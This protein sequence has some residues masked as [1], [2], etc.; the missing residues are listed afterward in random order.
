MIGFLEY[1]GTFRQIYEHEL[2]KLF[3]VKWRNFERKR[4]ALLKGRWPLY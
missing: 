2:K 1:H 3:A 4:N